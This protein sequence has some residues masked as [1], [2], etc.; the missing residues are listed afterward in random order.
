MS[1]IFT[2]ID[3][4]EIL[5]GD[6]SKRKPGS[7]SDPN[8]RIFN[9]DIF[10]NRPQ[11]QYDTSFNASNQFELRSKISGDRSVSDSQR[12]TKNRENSVGQKQ[13]VKMSNKKQAPKEKDYFMHKAVACILGFSMI[14]A[15]GMLTSNKIDE[16]NTRGEVNEYLRR[17][18]SIVSDSVYRN[19]NGTYWYDTLEMAQSVAESDDPEVAL[20]AAYM[21]LSYEPVKN[22]S[23]IFAIL[24]RQDSNFGGDA[25]T[26]SEYVKNMGCVDKN[27]NADYGIYKD[28]MASLVQAKAMAEEAGFDLNSASKK[29]GK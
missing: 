28:N 24:K 10:K 6:E 27:G 8:R 23:E 7:S 29:V 2:N 16:L 5:D 26:F 21:D 3:N 22:T 19:G 18:S 4:I 11:P 15:S 9:D 25:A 17:Y 14:F 20:Y 12:M 1:E 13:P